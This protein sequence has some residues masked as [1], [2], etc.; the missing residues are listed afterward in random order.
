MEFIFLKKALSDIV[1]CKVIFKSAISLA[2][3]GEKQTVSFCFC[4][5]SN[6]LF[7]MLAIRVCPRD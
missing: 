7:A 1:F 6:K 2:R 5:L 3:H 4:I